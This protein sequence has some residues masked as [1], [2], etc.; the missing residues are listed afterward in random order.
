VR[1]CFP[2]LLHRRSESKQQLLRQ[3]PM[4][5]LVT[6]RQGPPAL[7]Q[8]IFVYGHISPRRPVVS[9]RNNSR[10]IPGAIIRPRSILDTHSRK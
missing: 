3:L 8:C 4:K 2:Q 10:V 7:A 5:S 9:G 1:T 6:R